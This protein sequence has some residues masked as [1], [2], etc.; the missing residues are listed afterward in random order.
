MLSAAAA[1]GA[2]AGLL[3][4]DSI[5]FSGADAS[6]DAP[7]SDGS[8]D[9]G[10]VADASD[11]SY[12]DTYVFDGSAC[13]AYELEVLSDNPIAYWPL[14]D[15]P[16]AP[17][18]RQLAPNGPDAGFL[19]NLIRED[20]GV[21][22]PRTIFANSS[23]TSEGCVHAGNVLAFSD[24]G[25][26][27]FTVEAWVRLDGHAAVGSYPRIASYNYDTDASVVPRGQGYSLE[28]ETLLPDASVFYFF[29]RG[30]GTTANP[31]LNSTPGPVLV[32][33]VLRHT[34]LTFDGSAMRL[35]VDGQPQGAAFP[36]QI[37][38]VPVAGSF[39]I[40]ALPR[41]DDCPYDYFQGVIQD[42]ALYDR[43]LSQNDLMRH[44]VRGPR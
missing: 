41:G 24:A 6:V 3:D 12:A 9:D 26:A 11:A 43:V 27:P 23:G 20:G 30:G 5:Q 31:D 22:G 2:C 15:L 16:T 19:Y 35:Y 1:I 38:F 34:A 39:A 32:P 40:G 29:R 17:R 8:R 4:L 42:V 37:P 36:T 18:P 28:L 7:A 21:C 14:R 33:G 13:G 10:G 25:R 44:V